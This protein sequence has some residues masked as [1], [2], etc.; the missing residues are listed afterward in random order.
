MLDIRLFLFYSD[1]YHFKITISF[2]FCGSHPIVVLFVRAVICK[3]LFKKKLCMKRLSGKKFIG[4]SVM[5]LTSHCV[6]AGWLASFRSVLS[7]KSS[8]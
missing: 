2:A 7:S 8:L 6:T 1:A 5:F 3:L 4:L